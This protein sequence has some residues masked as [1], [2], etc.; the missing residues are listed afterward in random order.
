[1]QTTF[2]EGDKV[3]AITLDF[4]K[5]DVHL[6]KDTIYTVG[7]V[8]PLNILGDFPIL[9]NGK[10]IKGRSVRNG[11]LKPICFK[12]EHFEKVAV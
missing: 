6:N 4:D 12:K 5:I 8:N 10:E 1:M 11:C 2:Q 7:Y 9:E 3:K